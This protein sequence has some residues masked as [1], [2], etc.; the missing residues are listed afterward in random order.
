[1]FDS[2][3][4]LDIFNNALFSETLEFVNEQIVLKG[5]FDGGRYGTE[6]IGKG[7]AVKKN[8]AMQSFK[9]LTNSIPN[10]LMLK[11]A[12]VKVRDVI[13]KVK[14]TEGSNGDFTVLYLSKT[15]V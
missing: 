4:W 1:M 3:V 2:E 8:I 11:G 15:T 6:D 14:D 5:F 9:V 10:S 7:Y 13:Y 12:N